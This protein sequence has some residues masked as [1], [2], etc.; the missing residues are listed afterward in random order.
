MLG[1]SDGVGRQLE[2]R[3][4]RRGQRPVLLAETLFPNASDVS[5]TLPPILDLVGGTVY[6]V[7]TV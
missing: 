1:N 5:L 2:Q 6:L 4:R 3:L 7:S